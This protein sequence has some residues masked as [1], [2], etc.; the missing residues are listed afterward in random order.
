MEFSSLDLGQFELLV[1]LL[2]KREGF[3]VTQGHGIDSADFIARSPEGQ[4][5]I[6]EVKHYRKHNHLPL[7]VLRRIVG[8]INRYR[9]VEN[10]SLSLLATSNQVPPKL[11]DELIYQFPFQI[12]DRV[13]L[14]QLLCKY[15]DVAE[16]FTH[17]SIADQALKAEIFSG[18]AQSS[19]A[20][21]LRQQLVNL[22]PGLTTWRKYEELGV[23]ILSYL[24]IPPLASPYIQS[25]SEDNLDIRD[26][27]YP[28]RQ[29][30]EAWDM[31]RSE[32]RSRFV[33]AEFK[34][35]SDAI[36][37][38]KV[39][40][41]QQYLFPKAMRAFGLLLTRKKPSENAIKAR[42]RAWV[43]QE[44]LIV[45]LSDEEIFD[46]LNLRESGNDPFEVIDIQ[47]EEFFINLSP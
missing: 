7:S 10:A 15:P 6:V 16:K 29:G 44:K 39:E 3:L 12:W 46:M 30:S 8:D 42:R 41:L 14:E 31:L 4:V 32:C 23:K 40:S 25:R 11:L 20:A 36:T 2:L 37:Q 47:L 9:D 34:N 18:L 33:V 35:Y 22:V 38:R 26:A 28:I 1:A 5:V 43:E 19:Q 17:L 24:F 27:I 13:K 45:I 21:L